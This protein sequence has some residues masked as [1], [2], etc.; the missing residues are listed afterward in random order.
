MQETPVQILRH[1]AN[2]STAKYHYSFSKSNRFHNRSG[3]TNTI[4]YNLPS[5]V[6]R[7]NTGF[8]YGDRSK[9]F[10][11]QNVKNPSPGKY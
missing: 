8:G 3:Y 6:T 7:R 9:F 5:S 11:G 10:E 1:Q 2:N 4:S